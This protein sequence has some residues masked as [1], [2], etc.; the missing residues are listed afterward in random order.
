[1]ISSISCALLIGESL[2]NTSCFHF[3]EPAPGRKNPCGP[4][5]IWFAR[6]N[7]NPRIVPTVNERVDWWSS[8][9]ISIS[10]MLPLDKGR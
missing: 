2:G 5:S 10:F 7:K 4:V 8:E 6:D 3:I 1:M 9:L